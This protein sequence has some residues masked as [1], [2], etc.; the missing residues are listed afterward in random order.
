MKNY[1]FLGNNTMKREKL[2]ELK[3]LTNALFINFATVAFKQTEYKLK[4]RMP[5]TKKV[6]S[7]KRLM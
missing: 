3:T 4:N 6:D 7:H 2:W 1:F 5:K